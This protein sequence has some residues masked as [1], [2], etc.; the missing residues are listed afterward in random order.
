MA[1][2]LL[3]TSVFYDIQWKQIRSILYLLKSHNNTDVTN[4]NAYFKPSTG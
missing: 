1:T 2:W 4:Q 3:T